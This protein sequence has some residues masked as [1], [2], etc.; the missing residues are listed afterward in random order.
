MPGQGWAPPPN[1]GC[2]KRSGFASAKTG[3]RKTR[4]P[5][6]LLSQEHASPGVT[7]RGRYRVNLCGGLYNLIA[8]CCIC[9]IWSIGIMF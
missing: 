9:M 3:G 4:V 6:L 2:A 8:Y 1:V 5:G 7:V